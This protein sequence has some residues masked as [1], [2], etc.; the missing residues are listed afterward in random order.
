LF[1][2]YRT[3]SLGPRVQPRADTGDVGT[4]TS[5]DTFTRAGLRG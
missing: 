5:C 3:R 1:R 2:D 4:N